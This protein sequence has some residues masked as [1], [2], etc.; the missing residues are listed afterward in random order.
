[1]VDHLR[2]RGER[3]GLLELQTLWPFP[4]QVVCDAA[5]QAKFVGVVE[6]N[7]GQIAGAVKLAVE[8]PE[9]VFLINRVDGELITDADIKKNLRMIQ[10]RGA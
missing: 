1:V 7:M 10:G 9:R 2:K 4:R 6:M 3:I 8:D 5:R